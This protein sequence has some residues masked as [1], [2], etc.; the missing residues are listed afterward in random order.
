MSF[1][2]NDLVINTIDLWRTYRAGTHQ[3]VHALKG[4][5]LGVEAGSYFALKGRSGSGKTTL[6]NLI[7]GLD[8]P[9]KGSVLVFDIKLKKLKDKS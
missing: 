3:E 5:N 1:S 7:G 9:I 6:L 8:R 4:V 2:E